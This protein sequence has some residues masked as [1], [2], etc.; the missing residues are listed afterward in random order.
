M[1]LFS[2]GQWRGIEAAG[3]VLHWQGLSASYAGAAPALVRLS[4]QAAALLSAEVVCV[5]ACAAGM[6]VWLNGALAVPR[7]AQSVQAVQKLLCVRAG[8]VRAR[9]CD[10]HGPGDVRRHGAATCNAGA[11]HRY[12]AARA[13]G[14]TA[15]SLSAPCSG[16]NTPAVAA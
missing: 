11:A 15:R 4:V 7:A 3:P 6:N 1:A 5:V 2:T 8:L 13:S 9:P 10:K 12:A 16:V 14:A